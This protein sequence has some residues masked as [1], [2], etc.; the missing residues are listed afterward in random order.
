[1]DN[2]K[3]IKAVIE[4]GR[5]AAKDAKADSFAALD[6]QWD[7][8]I[9]SRDAEFGKTAGTPDHGRNRAAEYNAFC[10]GY[11]SHLNTAE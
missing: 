7:A 10:Y 6:R 8:F 2:L 9:E 11:L 5:E 1:M 3:S 4:A